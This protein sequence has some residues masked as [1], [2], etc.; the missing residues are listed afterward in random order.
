MNIL[1]I[2][3]DSGSIYFLGSETYDI[4]ESMHFSNHPHEPGGLDS[5]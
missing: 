2:D 5:D 3:S 1:P 4:E